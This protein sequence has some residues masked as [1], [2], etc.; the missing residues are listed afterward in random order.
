MVCVG[1]QPHDGEQIRLRLS[2][3]RAR[4]VNDNFFHTYIGTVGH[5]SRALTNHPRTVPRLAG[6]H[7]SGDVLSGMA[8]F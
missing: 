8:W 4:P 3:P 5:D 6:Q 7:D 1:G 2:Q